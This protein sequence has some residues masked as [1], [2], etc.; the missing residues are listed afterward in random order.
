MLNK[1]ILIGRMTKDPDQRG[2]D[3]E[4]PIASFRIAVDRDYKRDGEPEADFFDCS[5]F[6]QQAKFVLQYGRK[7]RLLC[8]VG[9]I[10]RCE[11]QDQQTGE[12]RSAFEVVRGDVHVLDKKPED[13]QPDGAAQPA[14]APAPVSAPAPAAGYAPQQVVPAAQGYA[15]PPAVQPAAAQAPQP[16]A[17]AQPSTQPAAA[18]APQAVPA[19]TVQ[20]ASALGYPQPVPGAAAQYPTPSFSGVPESYAWGPGGVPDPNPPF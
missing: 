18:P 13:A 20:A 7:G 15:A 19:V 5:V 8:V 2:K 16:A 6:G 4:K 14:A 9:A 3:P 12:K 10:Q 1:I 11:W 17:V